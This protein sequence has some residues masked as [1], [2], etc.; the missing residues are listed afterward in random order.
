MFSC[1]YKSFSE[2]YYMLK[3][4]KCIA[5]T[6]Y[7]C[8]LCRWKH[9]FIRFL[10]CAR[11]TINLHI[12]YKIGMCTKSYREREVSKL[13]QNYMQINKEFSNKLTLVHARE[14]EGVLYHENGMSKALLVYVLLYY[15]IICKSFSW[16]YKFVCHMY[17]LLFNFKQE[18]LFSSSSTHRKRKRTSS[19]YR[20]RTIAFVFNMC[21][22]MCRKN[23]QILKYIYTDWNIHKV[24]ILRNITIIQQSMYR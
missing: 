9:L 1:L 17:S 6:W 23:N 10:T 22:W 18:Q 15:K 24:W 16:S 13:W 2:Y 21:V 7:V 14:G 3:R 12:I 19:L 11:R 8:D 4:R 5:Y 20:R